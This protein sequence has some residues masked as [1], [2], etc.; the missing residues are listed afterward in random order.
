[1]VGDT[2]KQLLMTAWLLPLLGFVVEIFFG[3]WSKNPR[4]SKAAAWLAVGCI[5]VGFLCSLTALVKWGNAG[6]VWA[7][8][9]EIRAKAESDPHGHGHGGG[10]DHADPGHE[11][12]GAIKQSPEY[13]LTTTE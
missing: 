4:H 11:K 9:A 6:D 5:G 13:L 12:H 10:S 2:L 1:M 3:Y 8:N 7:R